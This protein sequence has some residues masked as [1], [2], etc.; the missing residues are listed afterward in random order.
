MLHIALLILVNCL[1]I[2][3]SFWH[4]MQKCA[5]YCVGGLVAMY[6]C[7]GMSV[8]KSDDSSSTN[9]TVLIS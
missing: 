8:D 4:F 1:L 7:L 9:W 5:I 2:L 6:N 3:A